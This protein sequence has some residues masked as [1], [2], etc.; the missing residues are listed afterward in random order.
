MPQTL[1]LLI[2]L[3]FKEPW[4][5]SLPQKRYQ[6]H[7]GY[8]EMRG[9]SQSE[10][11]PG[12]QGAAPLDVGRQ[13]RGKLSALAGHERRHWIGLLPGQPPENGLEIVAPWIQ[14]RRQ[15]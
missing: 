13:A 6:W 11:A 1:K 2:V 15:F 9:L 4:R 5:V 14:C 12:L 10:R 3:G 8:D 7:S